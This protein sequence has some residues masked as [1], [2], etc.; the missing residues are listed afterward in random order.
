VRDYIPCCPVIHNIYNPS[1]GEH[2]EAE[3]RLQEE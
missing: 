1:E 2:G 3:R